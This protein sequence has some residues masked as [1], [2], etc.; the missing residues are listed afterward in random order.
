MFCPHQHAAE[1]IQSEHSLSLL[2]FLE[3]GEGQVIPPRPWYRVRVAFFPRIGADNTGGLSRYCFMRSNAIWQS[4]SHLNGT[5]FWVS[6]VN[7]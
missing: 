7:C 1:V 4:E 6:L 5:S 2:R 3:L